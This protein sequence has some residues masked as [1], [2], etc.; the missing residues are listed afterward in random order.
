MK[1]IISFGV[2]AVL[3]TLSLGNVSAGFDVTADIGDPIEFT[4]RLRGGVE[5][6]V[7]G[8]TNI[9]SPMDY[10]R[11]S[12]DLDQNYKENMRLFYGKVNYWVDLSR[13]N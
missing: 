11:M 2:V 6:L 7:T 10:W 13:K 8:A 12:G 4:T 5:K 3:C 1:K 9:I